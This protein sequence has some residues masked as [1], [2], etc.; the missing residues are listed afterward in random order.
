MSDTPEPMKRITDVVSLCLGDFVQARLQGGQT[1]YYG[2][3]ESV[4][5]RHGFLWIR[6]GALKERKLLDASEYEIWWRPI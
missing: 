5:F 4:D 1:I 6:H 3:V 2:E